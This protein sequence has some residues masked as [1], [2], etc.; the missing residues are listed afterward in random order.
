MLA[1][2]HIAGFS[3]DAITQIAALAEQVNDQ[4]EN[5]GARR[6][7]TIMEK[8]LEDLAY[9]APEVGDQ[10]VHINADYVRSRLQPLAQ[11]QDLSRYIL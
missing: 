10:S 7:H 9:A 8:L 1:T 11:N 4:T 5:I 2:E 6:L 3:E